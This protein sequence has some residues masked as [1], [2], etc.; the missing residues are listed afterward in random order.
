MAKPFSENNQDAYRRKKADKKTKELSTISVLSSPPVLPLLVR[1]DSIQQTPKH[2]WES[3]RA[4]HPTSIARSVKMTG[5]AAGADGTND[6]GRC[7]HTYIKEDKYHNL[8]ACDTA[9]IFHFRRNLAA[10]ET[11]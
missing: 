1:E 3:S 9:I 2:E 11:V 4:H 6:E 8:A 5:I 10:S 7:M